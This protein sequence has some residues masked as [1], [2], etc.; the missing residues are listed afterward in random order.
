[1]TEDEVLALFE[2]CSN[3]GRWGPD[4]ELGTLNH[5]TP[6]RRLAAL[7]SVT[8]GDVVPFGAALLPGRSRETPPSARMTLRRDATSAFDELTLDVHGFEATHLDALGH[9]FFE[10]R[11]WNGRT[12][13]DVL[14]PEGLAFASVEAAGAA[15][16]VTRGV[17]LDV[18]AVH[19]VPF[20]PAGTGVTAADLDAAEARAGVRIGPGDAIVVRTGHGLRAASEGEAHD[21]TAPHEGVTADVVPWLFERSVAVWSGDC[22]DQ[23]P[24][25]YPRVAMPLH[26][27]GM[28]SMGLCLLDAP[29]VERLAA[30]CARHG[31][32]TFALVIAPLRLPGGTA[33]PVNPLALF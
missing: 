26:Q 32:A 8:A 31:R 16:I 19:G 12:S 9:V 27:V 18:A 21:E 6:A 3:V 4:D 1:M 29:D 30:A 28:V 33:S 15:G 24:S 10:E 23:R 11:A 14:R 2:R 13:A 7:A 5:I 20:L 22:I 25:G 17:L